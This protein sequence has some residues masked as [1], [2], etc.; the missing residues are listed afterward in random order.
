MSS[1]KQWALIGCVVGGLGLGTWG[2]TK[3][4]PPPEGADLGQRI[5]AFRT[6][7]L[8]TGDS[9]EI[10]EHYAGQVTLVNVWATWCVPCRE[11][12]PAL[13]RLQAELGGPDFEVAYSGSGAS[14]PGIPIWCR[15][16]VP[17]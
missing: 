8:A 12:M 5:P 16:L 10:R 11:E 6:L 13:D 1:L 15:P 4:A 9:V 14:R 2:L 17:R 7:L 3:L